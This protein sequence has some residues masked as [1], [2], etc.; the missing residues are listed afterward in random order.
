MKLRRWSAIALMIGAIAVDAGTMTGAQ[1]QTL[2]PLSAEQTAQWKETEGMQAEIRRLQQAG[3]RDKAIPLA[4]KVVA[5]AEKVLPPNHPELALSLNNL[6]GLYQFQGRLKEAEPLFQRSLKIAE[7]TPPPNHFQ[8][9]VLN[10]DGLAGL[11]KLQGRLKEAE[12]LLQRA[13]KILETALPP[14]HPDLAE[15][16]ISLASLYQNQGR[17]KEA[18][19]LLQRALKIQE[20]ALPPNHPDLEMGLTTLGLVY[21]DQGRLKEAEPL[22]QRV[23]RIRETTLSPT[24]VLWIPG[25]NNL[26]GLY[27]AQGRLKEAEPLYQRALK[28]AETTVSPT[29]PTFITILSNVAELYKAQGR[30]REAESLLQRALKI[31]ETTLSPTHPTLAATLNNLSGLYQDQGR[32]K[33]A[34]PLLQRVLKIREATQP[35]DYSNLAL[36]LNNLGELYRQ[37]GQ[38][39]KAE[40]LLQRALKIQEA[41]LPLNHPGLPHILNNLAA[42]YQDQ[43]RSSEATSLFQRALKIREAT[44]P[45]NHPDLAIASNNLATL[46]QDQ[47]RSSEATSLFQRALKIQEATLPPNH[48]DLAL[49]LSNLAVVSLFP[50]QRNLLQAIAFLNRSL[51]IQ[52][53]NLQQNLIVGSERNKLEFAQLFSSDT[54]TAISIAAQIAPNNPQAKRLAALTL[55]RRKGRVLDAVSDNVQTLRE[56]LKDKPDAQKL[57]DQWATIQQKLSGLSSRET[58]NLSPEQFKAT[59]NQLDGKR[60]E[61][62]AAISSQ[63][64]EF[65]AATKPIQLADIQSRIPKDAALVEMTIYDTFNPNT[66]SLLGAPHYAAM[67]L[68]STGEP[69][70]LDLGDAASINQSVEQFR[71]DLANPQVQPDTDKHARQLDRQVM[72]P[73]RKRLGN[74]QHILLSPDGALN[75]IPFEALQDENGKEL[76]DRYAFSYLT[77]GRDLVRFAVL[78]S[79]TNPPVVLADIDYNNAPEIASATRG[80]SRRSRDLTERYGELKGAKAEADL[81]QQ[82]YPNA[83]LLRDKAAS[84]TALRQVQAPSILHFATHGFYLEDQTKTFSSTPVSGLQKQPQQET[85][86]FENPLLRSGLA[87]SGFNSRNARR[88]QS[89]DGVLTALEVASLNLWG[90]QLVVLSAC[91]TGLGTSSV[92][93]GIY[94][95]RRAFAIAGAQS[96]I[97][98]LWKVNDGA[99]ATLMREYYT[100]LQAG[101]GRHEALRNAQRKLKTSS[102]YRHPHYWAGFIPSGE[103]GPLKGQ[104]SQR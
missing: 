15:S 51:T 100:G 70:W 93:E 101:L 55:L 42:L 83:K 43:G 53:H 5:I 61:L 75:Q 17:L 27:Q 18:E 30:L 39:K 45:P 25:L 60:R 73:I 64:A 58:T 79:S 20:T 4:E 49:T 26:A 37:Q 96:Q 81:L 69:E 6:A 72:Q 104:I 90:T 56:H 38:L 3:E 84:E 76:I 54:S 24:D 50:T 47:G 29:H 32:L 41:T 12:P 2:P 59:F 68:R 71:L 11:Y 86:K 52:E 65:L 67:I 85:F 80:G 89:D 16:L 91:E 92:G 21:Q 14:N 46:Y 23:L 103:W 63:S 10:L 9:L 48:P 28:I 82:I 97:I 88:D 95:L 77:S 62:E 36:S 33:E 35:P 102:Q 87:L 78:P 94:G 1:E 98:S 74:V 34:E 31:A 13:L 66:K 40:P 7:T 19:P 57:L 8:L 99:T 22:F 44:L